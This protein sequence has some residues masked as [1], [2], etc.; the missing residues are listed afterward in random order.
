MVIF[1]GNM[2]KFTRERGVFTKERGVCAR[3]H[4]DFSMEH[5]VS[6]RERRVFTRDRG[7]S[8]R[9]LRVFVREDGDFPCFTEGKCV[10]LWVIFFWGCNM[11]SARKFLGLHW[12]TFGFTLDSD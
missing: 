7:D 5:R 4:G 3:E 11:H 10:A 2:Q 6:A 12:G 9:E 8:T 1:Q